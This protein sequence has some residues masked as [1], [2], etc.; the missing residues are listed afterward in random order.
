[1]LERSDDTALTGFVTQALFKARENADGGRHEGIPAIDKLPKVTT[2]IFGLGGHDLQSRHI[3]AAFD[4]M[5]AARNNP[6]VYLGSQF[7]S[8]NPN[9]RMSEV[10]AKLKAAF[11]RPSS[12]RWRRARTPAC[13]LTM[14][15]AS[16]S[17]RWAVTA[18]SPPASS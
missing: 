12:W 9:A 17:T 10:Q 18:P 1:M 16:A 4:N 11:R 13:C 8:K 15:S 5:E 6:F 2:A 14:P 7:F 3:V